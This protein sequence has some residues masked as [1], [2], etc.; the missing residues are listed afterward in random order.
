MNDESTKKV[1]DEPSEESLADM[2]DTTDTTRFRPRPGRGHHTHLRAGDLVRIDAD[3][4]EHFG[5][6]DGAAVTVSTVIPTSACV[7]GSRADL[8]PSAQRAVRRRRRGGSVWSKSIL[9]VVTS[10]RASARS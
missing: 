6:A 9:N 1:S 8:P 4:L 10:V 3:L 5:S 7:L 2:P